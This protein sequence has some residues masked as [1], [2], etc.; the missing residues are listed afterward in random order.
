M[1]IKA[2]TLK[3]RTLADYTATADARLRSNI[4]LVPL[5][6]LDSGAIA[7]LYARWQ[8]NASTRPLCKPTASFQLR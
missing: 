8:D 5:A 7:R 1:E 2:P 3:P 6:R 4:G